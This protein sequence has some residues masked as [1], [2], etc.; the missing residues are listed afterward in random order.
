MPSANS[1]DQSKVREIFL[2]AL[3]KATPQEREA[4]LDG[5]CRADVALRE[6]IE[7]LL[8]SHR[9]DD[10]LEVP[11]IAMDRIGEATACA[12]SEKPG[13]VIGRYK[14]L[15]KIGEGG[16]GLVYVAEQEEPVRRRV[17]LKVIKLGMDTRQVIARFE[18]ERQ[19]LALMDHPNIAKV[20]DAGETEG[21][22]PYFVMEL[23]KGIPITRHC[24]ENQ[25]STHGRL[26][27]F[28]QVCQAIQ[29]AHQKGIIHRD[30][31]PSNILVANHDG[32]PVPKVIDFGIAKA[33][34]DQRLTDKTLY[35]AIEQFIGTPAY[36]SPEQANL[37]SL[38]VDTRSD[39]YSLGV[40]LYEL[41]TGRTPFDAQELIKNGL[42]AVRQT[43]RE[44]EPPPPSKRLSTLQAETLT[45]TSK[46]HGTESL[47]LLKMVRGD[48]DWIV[49]KCL[50]KDRTRRYETANGLARDLERHLNDEPVVARPPSAAYRLQKFVR[51]NK[52]M[53]ASTA[54]VVL[55]LV[56]GVLVSTWQ[57]IRATTA[58]S[59]Q[60]RLRQSA[61]TAQ[62]NEVRQRQRAEAGEQS[63]QRLLYA[64]DM[65]LAQQSMLDGNWGRARSLLAAH[66]PQP[67]QPDL[68]GFEWRYLWSAMKGD[69]LGYAGTNRASVTSLAVSPDGKTL[70]AIGQEGPARV[71]DLASRKI[72]ATITN[73]GGA[74]PAAAFS[75]DGQTLAVGTGADLTLYSAATLEQVLKPQSDDS[76]KRIAFSPVGHLLA[77][78]TR[79]TWIGDGGDV[80]VEKYLTGE[81]VA[82]FPGAGSQVAFSPDA[83]LLAMGGSN[84]VTT[85]VELATGK[86]VASLRQRGDLWTMAFTPDGQGLLTSY[87]GDGVLDLWDLDSQQV[88]RSLPGH[89]AWVWQ[90]AFSPD[91]R[92][93]A[94]ASSDETVRLW[95][96]ATWQTRDILRGH[97]R[98]VWAV[99][100]TPDGRHLLTGCG[101]AEED[102]IM[103]W[104]V[105]PPRKLELIQDV[106]WGPVFSPDGSLIATASASNRLVL[107]STSTGETAGVIE[108]GQLPLGF[109]GNG[110]VLVTVDTNAVL[111]RWDVP[112]RTVR[113][114]T[115]LAGAGPFDVFDLSPDGTM[116][117]TAS[118]SAEG[119]VFDAKVW[120]AQT[121]ELRGSLAQCTNPLGECFS[122]DNRRIA[123][124]YRWINAVVWDTRTLKQVAKF[125][126]EAIL[127]FRSTAFSPDSRSLATGSDDGRVVLWDIASQ[128]SLA[129]LGRQAEGIQG[130]SFSPDGKTLAAHSHRIV[131]LWNLATGHEVAKFPYDGDPT[132]S[133][134]GRLLVLN[135]PDDKLSLVRALTFP[136]IEA[137]ERIGG[138]ALM[139][140]APTI[141][142]SAAQNLAPLRQ[143]QDIDEQLKPNAWSR[144]QSGRWAEAATN[145]ARA[146]EHNPADHELWWWLGLIYVQT[147]QL[148]AYRENC[149]KSL[150][151]FSETTEPG[152]A[153]EIA[154]NCMILPDSGANLDTV[155]K[156]ADTA[157]AQGRDS[158]YL[159][160][161]Q[162]CKG[163]A[164][165]RQGRFTSAADWMG[166]VLTNAGSILERDTEAYMVLAMSQHQLRQFAQARA[167][168]AYG[169]EIEQKLPKLESGDL[170]EH[171]MDWIIAHA[172]M[173][174]AKAMIGPA[175]AKP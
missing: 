50:E 77:C 170:G 173:R 158:P 31:K 71:I 93:M 146:I 167:S 171:W 151:K 85:V 63:A 139:F 32:V 131:T 121:G 105:D 97:G 94:T 47:Q 154:K 61:Q 89:T 147:G 29:H 110:G 54:A 157:V 88:V 91:G 103:I 22:R 30:L 26:T 43:I 46:Q 174:E 83:K 148:D 60:R 69:Q 162:F 126:T 153:D 21:G 11:A 70:V 113:S 101:D 3:E 2:E 81:R 5:A 40:L 136:E 24:D 124:I 128:Q 73:A 16:C 53:V 166:T 168:L 108:G 130:V 23:V 44:V 36:M 34:T 20:L 160:W 144:A 90:I 138:F 100:F 28:I 18:A 56:L 42:E 8:K 149:R 78:A 84:G 39:I 172:L 119:E 165:Y 143:P 96:V 13:T 80:T 99:A 163:L 4:Y 106:H 156:M 7:G 65:S 95:D 122:P 68:R 79:E 116:L 82:R 14:L 155:S 76:L 9:Q 38:D 87:C 152:T 62:A 107:T 145:L 125:N 133:R 175:P 127:A 104:P 109:P 161:Y 12:P 102:P 25:M 67:G 169:A 59:E 27:L 37:S 92:T 33:T 55:V 45:V 15:E 115:K 117:F 111:T 52:V 134:D 150:E 41:L 123:T 142:P 19:A 132:F 1:P 66:L 49:M 75:P 6:K 74:C 72:R 98:A 17:A 114:Q 141:G 120:D 159:A 140:G 58:E 48:L 112:T 10:F 164:E 118:R 135:T 64:S 129:T 137:A 35:T 86:T 57:A 51:R